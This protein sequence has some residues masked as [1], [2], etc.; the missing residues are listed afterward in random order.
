MIIC[1][2]GDNSKFREEVTAVTFCKFCGGNFMVNLDELAWKMMT[3]FLANQ[4][5]AFYINLNNSY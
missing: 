5:T 2:V 3:I 1:I 4:C